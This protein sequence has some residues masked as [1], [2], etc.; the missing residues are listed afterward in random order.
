MDALTG[1]TGVLRQDVFKDVTHPEDLFG[2][3][4]K[5]SDLTIANLSVWLMQQN[6]TVR[7]S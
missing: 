4:L 7:K 3:D 1:L 5:I 6:S 2:G